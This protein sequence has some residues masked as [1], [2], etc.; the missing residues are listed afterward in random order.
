MVKCRTNVLISIILLLVM[1]C[2]KC[3]RLV[4]GHYDDNDRSL[5]Y[6]DCCN[7][8]TYKVP[9]EF[10]ISDSVPIIKSDSKQQFIKKYIMPSPEFDQ[11]LQSSR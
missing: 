3:G 4:Q 8:V 10:L 1:Y 9:E 11:Y 5:C 6:C 7:S 2:K